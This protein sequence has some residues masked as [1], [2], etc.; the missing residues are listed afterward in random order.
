MCCRAECCAY[1]NEHWDSCN[2]DCC[3]HSCF[4]YQDH[5]TNEIYADKLKS[6]NTELKFLLGKVD[7]LT[8]SLKKARKSTLPDCSICKNKKEHQNKTHYKFDLIICNDCDRM[9]Q[10]SREIKEIKKDKNIYP[11]SKYPSGK[12]RKCSK[13]EICLSISKKSKSKFMDDQI[14]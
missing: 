5:L 9:M 8:E 12:L 13:C 10:L 7:K 3:C 14:Y 6:S 11:L 2:S 4:S 1:F